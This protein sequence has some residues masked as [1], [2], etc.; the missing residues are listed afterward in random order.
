MLIFIN[1]HLSVTGFRAFSLDALRAF[2]EK[3]LTPSLE[4]KGAMFLAR[5]FATRIIC[6]PLG[7]ERPRAD[8]VRSGA[9]YVFGARFIKAV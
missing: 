7:R 3:A 8:Y 2:W 6:A 4:A 1:V 5:G 9:F